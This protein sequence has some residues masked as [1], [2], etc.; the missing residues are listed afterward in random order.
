[1]ELG[2]AEALGFENDHDR[3]IGDVDADFDDGGGDEG[4]EFPGAEAAHHRFLFLRLQAA[5]HEPS[6]KGGKLFL[7]GEVFLGGGFEVDA[8]TF[9]DERVDKIG[10]PAGFELL[11]QKRGH[12]IEI[13]LVA[14]GSNDRAATGG[15][16]VDEADVEVAV[17]G[18]GQ[19]TGDGRGGHH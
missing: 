7:P 4:V 5:M 17:D 12:L 2:E 15:E 18:E 11:F 13:R 19:G 1:M 8:I 10:L 6:G 3:G 16:F 9:V 14:D